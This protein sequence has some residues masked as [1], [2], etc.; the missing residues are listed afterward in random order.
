[1]DI[2]GHVSLFIDH[3]D[4][5]CHIPFDMAFE[6][7]PKWFQM[8]QTEGATIEIS[9]KTNKLIWHGGTWLNGE[10]LDGIW[11]C[12]IWNNGTWHNGIWEIGIWR[13]GVWIDGQWKDGVWSKGVFLKGT[14]MS[15]TFYGFDSEGYLIF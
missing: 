4:H 15:E 5:P 14:Y 1:M 2:L 6:K 3:P 11:K 12:G 8:A 9:P 7:L 10:W 13:N